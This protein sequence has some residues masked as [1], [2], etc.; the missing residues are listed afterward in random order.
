MCRPTGALGTCQVFSMCRMQSAYSTE[1]DCTA[2]VACSFG[3]Q[4][5][6]RKASELLRTLF[7]FCAVK[8]A[9]AW[10]NLRTNVAP[11]ACPI[12][13]PI[14]HARQGTVLIRTH[15]PRLRRI[16]LAQMEGSGR[17]SLG[18]YNAQGYVR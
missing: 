8:C 5:P 9:F 1:T 12:T 18:S 3:G 16:V 6:E 2:L 4:S 10:A 15:A 11:T 7:T 17:G 13:R 14:R